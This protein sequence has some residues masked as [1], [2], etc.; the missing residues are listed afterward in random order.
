MRLAPY[1][2]GDLRTE[3]VVVT[4][5]DVTQLTRA[6]LHQRLLMDELN[7]RVKNTLATVQ[8][9]ASQSFRGVAG[10]EAERNAFSDRL[11]A[12]AAA[13]D[14]LTAESWEGADLDRIVQASL[15]PFEPD[16]DGDRVRIDG[17]AVRLAPRAAVAIALH[18][19]ATNAVKYG[20]LST[21]TGSVHVAWRVSAGEGP[22]DGARLRLR[23]EE[24]GGPAVAP[25]AGRGFGS[26][27][28][29]AG[30]AAELQGEATLSYEPEGLVCIV[31]VPLHAVGARA[32]G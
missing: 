5:I 26:R 24:R 23:W 25:P 27:L 18:E 15:G 6:Q 9:I 19:L 14:V 22:G 29:E 16:N 17:P 4:F 8:A 11:R 7:H 32:E 1:R 2:D 31:D 10:P 21:R 12:L 13:H 20:A 3:G 28:I 30:L